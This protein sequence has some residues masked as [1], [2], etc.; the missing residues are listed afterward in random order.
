[1]AGLPKK[2]CHYCNRACVGK[3]PCRGG[4]PQE[5]RPTAC[6]RGYGRKWQRESKEFLREHPLCVE[7]LGEGRVVPAEAVDHKTPHRGDE[8]LFWDKSN[9]QPLC[10]PHHNRKSARGD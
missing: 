2:V 4:T 5:Q 10:V 8:V 9:W 1:M 6:Q 3:C 7:C